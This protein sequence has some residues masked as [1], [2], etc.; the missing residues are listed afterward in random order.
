MLENT[1]WASLSLPREFSPAQNQSG[2]GV[3]AGGSAPTA[4]AMIPSWWVDANERV[5]VLNEW[6]LM[7][8]AGW[9]VAACARWIFP[10]A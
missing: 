9:G 4:A 10:C 8:A 3:E 7:R 5:V 2:G 1:N 6:M